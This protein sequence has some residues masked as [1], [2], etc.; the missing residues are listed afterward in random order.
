MTRIQQDLVQNCLE[1]CAKF[2]FRGSEFTQLF[3]SPFVTF[4][5]WEGALFLVPPQILY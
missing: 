3:L 1:W 2:D 4:F 5:C